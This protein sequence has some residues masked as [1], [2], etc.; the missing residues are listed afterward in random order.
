MPAV[1]FVVWPEQSR[2]AKIERCPRV[3]MELVG[4]SWGEGFLIPAVPLPENAPTWLRAAGSSQARM[5]IRDGLRA[6]RYPD[7]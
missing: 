1:Q 6:S 2:R 4:W 3:A 7:E 5:G